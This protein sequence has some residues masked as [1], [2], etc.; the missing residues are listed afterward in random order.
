MIYCCTWC[1]KPDCFK[2]DGPMKNGASYDAA[3]VNQGQKDIIV[4]CIGWCAI[5]SIDF[6]EWIGVP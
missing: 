2:F 6:V 4:V 1:V 3:P 5:W